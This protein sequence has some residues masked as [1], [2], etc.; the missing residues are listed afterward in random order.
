MAREITRFA[1]GTEPERTT[2]GDELDPRGVLRALWRRKFWLV[3]TIGLFTAAAIGYVQTAVPLYRAETL[4]RIQPGQP[5]VIDLPEI[6]GTFEADASTIESEIELLNSRAFAARMIDDLALMDDAEFNTSLDP[7]RQPFWK[8]IDW[9]GYL[10]QPVGRLLLGDAFAEREALALDDR[11]GSGESDRIRAIGRFRDALSVGQ[12]SRSYVL[13]IRFVSEEPEKA[14]RIANA[15]AEAYIANQLETKF[16]TGQ[17]ATDWLRERVDEMRERVIAAEQR[18]VAFQSETGISAQGRADPL[19]QQIANL[20]GQLATAQATR[21]EAE[22]RFNQVR[23][24]LR[25]SGGVRAASNVLTSPLLANLRQEESLL[26]RRLSELQAVYG[27][28]HPQ[29]I[30]AEAEMAS[31]RSKMIDEVDR[32]VQDLSNEVE[33]ARARERE[34]AGSLQRLQADVQGQDVSS[35]ALRDLER[36]AASARELYE[37]FLQRLREVNEVQNLQQADAVVLSAAVLPVDPYWPDK[38]LIVVL[39][40]GAACLL[41]AVFV[42]LLERWDNGFGFRSAEEVLASSGL[43]ALALVPDLTRRETRDLTPEEYILKKPQSA[44]AEALQRV[45]TSIFLADR[46]RA[47][48][49][50]LVT[51][52]V[53][54]EGKSLISA[55]MARQSA[56]SGLRTLL[57]DADLRRPRL[58]EVFRVA[59]NN[60]LADLLYGDLMMSQAIRT[61]EKS[62]LRFIPAGLAPVSPPDL[63]RGDAMRRLLKEVT[64]DYD[65]VIIDSPPVGAVS[66]SLILSGLVDKTLY[67]V[68]WQQTPRNVANAGIRQIQEA[69]GDLAGVVLS[70]VDVKKHAQYGYAD[71]GSYAGTYGKYFVN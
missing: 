43:R 62:G 14:Y 31:L 67:V 16:A 42:F 52:S 63:F 44:F 23:S 30:N 55:A 26:Q 24:L 65:L 2:S 39:A 70:R 5:M 49:S 50:V 35:V 60:G 9:L 41:G 51:S 10:P 3:G 12:I 53:P 38:K 47:T 48:R 68:R 27:E 69:G 22:A 32:V 4:V 71:S 1:G 56:R 18:I 29:R 36:D 64:R 13:E 21:A 25:S 34:L 33:V 61:D 19:A 58:H 6:G 8:K 28:R 17:R 59:N 54:V 46:D 11:L 45:R 40:F 37:S 66:D 57:I 7:D 20:N 15:V